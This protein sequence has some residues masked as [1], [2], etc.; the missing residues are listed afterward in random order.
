METNNANGDGCVALEFDDLWNED[1]A[2][3]IGP[4]RRHR[5]SVR[6]VPPWKRKH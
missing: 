2:C 4:P 3:R 1:R 5:Q 6:G